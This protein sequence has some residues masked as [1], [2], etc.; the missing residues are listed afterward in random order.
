MANFA[1][2]VAHDMQLA[3]NTTT[4][5]IDEGIA[6]V[7]IDVLTGRPLGVCTQSFRLK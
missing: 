2:M 5:S 3:L 7:Q 1:E 4:D 6:N